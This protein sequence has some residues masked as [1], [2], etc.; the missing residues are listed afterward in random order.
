MRILALHERK[1]PA[2]VKAGAT[3]MAGPIGTA[4]A[5]RP[6]EARGP[7]MMSAVR[8]PYWFWRS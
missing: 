3:V 5:F 7:G 4:G 8:P 2:G 6:Q 1:P